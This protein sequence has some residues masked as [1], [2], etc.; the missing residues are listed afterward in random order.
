MILYLDTSSLV[1]LYGNYHQHKNIQTRV[2]EG[3]ADH[4]ER[5]C[6]HRQEGPCFFSYG[7]FPKRG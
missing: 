6:D 1:K 2:R 4:Q 7:V 3:R 5:S